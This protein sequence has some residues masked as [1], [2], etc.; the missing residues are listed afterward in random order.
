MNI[1]NNLLDAMEARRRRQNRNAAIIFGGGCLVF[2]VLGII[3]VIVGS[4]LNAVETANVN[5]LY[6]ETLASACQP[7][8]AGSDSTDNLPDVAT[9]RGLLLLESDTQRRHG[10]HSELP[11]QWRAENA[12]EVVL[13]G[14]VEEER[15][16]LETCEYLRDS[17]RSDDAYTVRI[18]REQYRTTLVLLNAQT[19]RR[20]DSQTLT[21]SEPE[22][23]PEDDGEF[24]SG[25]QRGDALAWADF[26]AWVET[27]VFE[28]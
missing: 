19:A 17:A 13:I 23:C 15:V 22:A 7:V 16:L 25:E 20:I 24:G 14:C 28:S 27:Y 10:W 9:P 1:I 5:N 11:A 18:R 26:A 12:D 4:I 21:G 2:V 6:G 8:P 3:I